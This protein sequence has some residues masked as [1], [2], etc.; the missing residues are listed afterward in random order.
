MLWLDIPDLASNP[1]YISLCAS[2]FYNFRKKDRYDILNNELFDQCLDENFLS[3]EYILTNL[4]SHDKLEI[5]SH[6]LHEDFRYN[7]H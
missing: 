6:D 4:T 1:V 7:Y 2:Y 3:S 5:D